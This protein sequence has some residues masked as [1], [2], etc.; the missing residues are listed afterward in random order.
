DHGMGVVIGET[1][2]IGDDVTIYHQ[3]TLGGTNWTREKRHPTLEDNVVVGAGAKILGAVTIGRNSK[4][5]AG[6][7][8]VKGCPPNSTV[9]G[10]PG[11]VVFVDRG[12]MMGERLNHA[13]LPDVEGKVIQALVDQMMD[14][15]KK[16]ATLEAEHFLG[17][18]SEEAER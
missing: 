18:S 16:I 11:R 13:D 3:V 17:D 15:E 5:G 2:V 7:V 6:S 1:A 9:V 8:V 10:I 4:V 12:G 14:L